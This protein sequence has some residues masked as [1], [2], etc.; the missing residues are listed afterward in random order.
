MPTRGS[1]GIARPSA[2]AD[3]S[4]DRRPPTLPS[5]DDSLAAARGVLLG[6]ACAIPMWLILLVAILS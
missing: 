3:S 1:K 4:P 2:P 6:F 5:C